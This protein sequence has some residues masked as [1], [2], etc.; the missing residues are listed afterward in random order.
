MV[1]RM[2]A[3]LMGLALLCSLAA[4]A[5][6]FGFLRALPEAATQRVCFD[7]P[8]ALKQGID[9]M[10][11]AIRALG[12]ATVERP[13]PALLERHYFE[14]GSQSEIP[15]DAPLPASLARRRWQVLSIGGVVRFMPAKLSG[16]LVFAVDRDV[17]RLPGV[18]P[19]AS[20]QVCGALP[21]GLRGVRPAF[22]VEESR[23]RWTIAAPERTGGNTLRYRGAEYRFTQT[24][25]PIGISIAAATVLLHPSRPSLMLVQWEPRD[26]DC[27]FGVT[28]HEL[29]T[30]SPPA[31]AWN[32]VD[33]DI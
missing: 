12:S 14:V 17:K 5:E 13:A 2:D 20:I 26:G 31:I 21:V 24:D 8:N 10:R 32:A 19:Q 28:L 33:C 22:V 25:H 27:A 1:V 11:L 3:A 23:D 30:A 16:R 29:V 7:I 6:D 4:Q 18:S 15:F 9:P